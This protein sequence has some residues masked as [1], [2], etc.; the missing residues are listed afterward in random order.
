MVRVDGHRP[1]LSG[2]FA[3]AAVVSLELLEAAAQ[4]AHFAAKGRD[5]EEAAEDTIDQAARG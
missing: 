2:A 1:Q 3:G 5:V 4:P